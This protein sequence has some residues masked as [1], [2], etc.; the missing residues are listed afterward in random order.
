MISILCRRG[1]LLRWRISRRNRGE[2]EVRL[3]NE[4]WK[5]RLWVNYTAV[6][7]RGHQLWSG[8]AINFIILS[9]ESN[10]RPAHGVTAPYP[11][12]LHSAWFSAAAQTMTYG[13]VIALFR[14][15]VIYQKWSWVTGQLRNSKFSSSFPEIRIQVRAPAAH[16]TTAIFKFCITHKM[17][18]CGFQV[19]N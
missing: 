17:I 12:F 15:E 14:P 5:F 19:K 8:W 10:S 11:L 4:S 13:L 7:T 18:V 16:L 3:A 6:P 9:R 1:R 2:R